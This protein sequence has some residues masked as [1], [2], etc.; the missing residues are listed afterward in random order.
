MKNIT[1][2]SLC[3]SLFIA[4]QGFAEEKK[5]TFA[6]D[7]WCPYN[8]HPTAPQPGY[9][10]NIL[11]SVFGKK[12]IEYSEIN[13]ARAIFETKNGNYNGIIAAGPNEAPGFIYT[14]HKV[15]MQ[16]VCFFTR[17]NST[18]KINS[19]KD[20]EG[21][22]LGVIKDYTYFH[23]LDAYIA[24]DSNKKFIVT[25]YGEKALSL[26]TK[27]LFENKI[28]LFVETEDVLAYEL[29]SN[30]A[31]IKKHYCNP[32]GNLYIAFSP[33]LKNSQE[34]ANQVDKGIDELIRTGKMDAILKQYGVKPWYK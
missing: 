2:F 17:A 20:I 8:C 21:Y 33:K 4:G 28:D 14:K 23:K 27:A 32:P 11:E 7:Y 29:K 25:H 5:Y 31:S 10:V 16:T 30:I 9:I 18:L 1:L 15:G 13:W 19:V 6:A 34:L 3:F 22:K 12:K 26:M 24:E